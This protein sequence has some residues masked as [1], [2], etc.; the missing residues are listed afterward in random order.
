M[1]IGR[2]M[3]NFFVLAIVAV[4]CL[5]AAA[6]AETFTVVD[7]GDPSPGACDPDSVD[8]GAT[9]TLREAVLAANA[10]AGAD[11]VTLNSAVSLSQGSDGESEDA[12]MTGD[13]DVLGG[14]LAITIG[15]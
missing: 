11:T 15:R 7:P 14:D 2:E 3:R 10:S 8:A 9:C 6:N 4:A 12:G 1:T 13:L 5:R